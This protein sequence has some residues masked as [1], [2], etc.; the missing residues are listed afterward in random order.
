MIVAADG[1]GDSRSLQEAVNTISPTNKEWIT[2][3]IKSGV[4]KEK[5]KEVGQYYENCLI[6][7]DIDFIFGS[8]TAVLNNYEFFSQE[9]ING[10]I[11]PLPP[12]PAKHSGMYF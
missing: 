10:Y 2:I 6:R 5:F 7:G 4:Y 11:T 1:S 8:A 12:L 9:R 3:H